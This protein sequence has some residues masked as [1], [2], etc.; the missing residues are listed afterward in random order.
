MHRSVYTNTDLAAISME[1]VSRLI[2]LLCII[3]GFI[4]NMKTQET[5]LLWPSF[6]RRQ[7]RAMAHYT[8]EVLWLNLLSQDMR[9]S[10]LRLLGIDNTEMPYEFII[11]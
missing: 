9:D 10:L 5:I 1:I 11:I 7:Y 3:R 2:W 8:F 6:P 4:N